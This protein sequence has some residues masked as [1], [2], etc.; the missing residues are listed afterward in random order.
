MTLISTVNVASAAANITF[1]SIVATY[2]DLLLVVSGRSTGTEGAGGAFF[3]IQPNNQTANRSYRVL[4]GNGSATYSSSDTT[5]Q[6]RIDPSDFTSN[7]F[8]SSSIYIPNYAGSTAKSLSID[9]VFENNATFARQEI[10]AARWN[11]SSA[12]TS[13]VLIPGDGNF[14]VGS[15]ASLYGIL[16]G[17]G[18]AT[19]S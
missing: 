13:L 6:A 5:I 10:H 19:V 14:A 15:S 4:G 2:T 18:G 17:S 3:T 8:G 9:T 11:D 7:T 16:K 1:S 12:I